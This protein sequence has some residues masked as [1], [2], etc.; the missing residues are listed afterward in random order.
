MLNLR[1]HLEFKSIKQFKKK[2]ILSFFKGVGSLSNI[3]QLRLYSKKGSEVYI[4][5]Y[6]CLLDSSHTVQPTTLNLKHTTPHVTILKLILSNIQNK[7]FR[8]IFSKISL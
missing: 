6:V 7:F 5:I 3:F 2:I 4:H 8:V 1:V